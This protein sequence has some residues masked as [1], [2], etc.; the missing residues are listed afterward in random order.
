MLRD[1]EIEIARQT[2][3]VKV[4]EVLARFVDQEDLIEIDFL[5]YTLLKV[6]PKVYKYAEFES[7]FG[8]V[9]ELICLKS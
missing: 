7:E 6:L 2:T 8:S 1:L 5:S 3:A 4:I 9:L